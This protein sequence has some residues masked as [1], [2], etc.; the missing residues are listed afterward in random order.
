MNAVT[1]AVATLLAA[2]RNVYIDVECAYPTIYSDEIII[3]AAQ[4]LDATARAMLALAGTPRIAR[5][6]APTLRVFKH[7]PDRQFMAGNLFMVM[8]SAEEI[9]Q[10]STYRQVFTY[11]QGIQVDADDSQLAAVAAVI[12]KQTAAL[13][14]L[15]ID[16]AR[17]MPGDVDVLALRR[18][19]WEMQGDRRP[20]T[21]MTM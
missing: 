4:P 11:R 14:E 16:V 18:A 10:K 9:Q 19:L 6:T 8:L 1:Q 5:F 15:V 2:N 17:L 12:T 21:Q 20:W 3:S 7:V 13:V